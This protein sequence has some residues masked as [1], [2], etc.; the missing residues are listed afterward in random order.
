LEPKVAARGKV[1]IDQAKRYGQWLRSAMKRR[2]WSA[3]QLYRET[4][5]LPAYISRIVN[6]RSIQPTVMQ[7][8]TLAEAFDATQNEI[9]Q[10]AGWWKQDDSENK[11]LLWE[12]RQ[13]IEIIRRLPPVL[14][15]TAFAQL[16]ALSIGFEAYSRDPV[17]LSVSEGVSASTN[18][19]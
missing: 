1:G 16:R 10:A 9:F 5:L 15:V 8:A 19:W 17:A 2:G 11:E 6:G 12:G 3:N 18:R 13:G 4:G 14:Q 7:V